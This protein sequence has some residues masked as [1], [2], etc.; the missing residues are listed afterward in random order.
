VGNHDEDVMGHHVLNVDAHRTTRVRGRVRGR[1]R[2]HHGARRASLGGGGRGAR[3]IEGED[4]GACVT[5]RGREVIL[6]RG[7]PPLA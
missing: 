6:V 3:E 2:E 1:R 7:T 4:R 5:G